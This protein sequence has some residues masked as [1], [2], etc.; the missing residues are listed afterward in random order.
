MP[1][2][3]VKGPLL[4]CYAQLA[5][6]VPG[7]T[8]KPCQLPVATT[9]ERSDRVGKGSWLGLS[10]SVLTRLITLVVFSG[11]PAEVDTYLD[12]V[13]AAISATDLFRFTILIVCLIF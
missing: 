8:I 2:V 12:S 1:A 4:D 10:I 11:F 13:V 3:L 9:M 6:F 5:V 7:S